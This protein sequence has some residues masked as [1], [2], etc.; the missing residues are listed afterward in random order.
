MVTRKPKGA[1]YRNLFARGKKGIIYYERLVDGQRIRRSTK[2]NLW[3]E[4]ASFR[5]LFEAEK[6]I[7]RVPYLL[8]EVP[9]LEDF[10][11]RYMAEDTAH[12]APT[13]RSD[14]R[15]YLSPKGP[16]MVAFGK[17]KLDAI[18]APLLREWWTLHVTHAGRSSK[19]GG[20][21]L[22]VLGSVLGYAKELGMFDRSWVNPLREFRETLKRMNRTARGRAHSSPGQHIRPIETAAELERLLEAAEAEDPIAFAF[23]VTLLDAGL[24][25]GEALGLKWGAIRWGADEDDPTR[26][27]VIAC[28]RPRGWEEGLTKSGR[29]RVVA[30]SRRLR[31]VLRDLYFSQLH[32]RGPE[33]RVFPGL[34]PREFYRHQWQ[35]ICRRAGLGHRALKDL[36]DTFASQLLTAGVQLGYVSKQLGHADVGVTARHYARWAG[37]D[38][39]R[40]PMQLEPGEVPADF[41]AR[42]ETPPRFPHSRIEPTR[43]QWVSEAGLGEIL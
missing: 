30:L 4:A 14:R 37:G 34:H 32:D 39:Y 18:S 11:D 13:T 31:S 12:L 6:K 38:L 29:T 23:V 40:A 43:N 15:S 7:G 26:T 24:R 10:I 17:M 42:L 16:L 3:E 8:A 25:V 21:Y 1:K 20:H 33:A 36:R 28:S 35:R 9:I 22:E 27:L 5:D 2:T 19:T 41:L